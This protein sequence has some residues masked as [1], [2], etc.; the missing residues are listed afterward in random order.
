MAFQSYPDRVYPFFAAVP[1]YEAEGLDRV[2]E[3]LE[4]GYFG[5]GEIVGASTQS[6]MTSQLEW[7]SEH[8]NDGNLPEI[9]D[10]C[11]EYRVPILLHIDPPEGFPIQMLEEALTQHP[12]TV[13]VFAHANAYNTPQNIE[14]LVS[15][16]PNLYVDFFAGFTA[17]NPDSTYGLEDFVA[18]IEG[19]PDQFLVGTDSGYGVGYDSAALATYELLDLLTAETA[20]KVSHQ[21]IARILETQLPTESQIARIK[22]LSKL[23]GESG[24]QRLNKRMAHE[25]L[26]ELEAQVSNKNE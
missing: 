14:A 2:R 23:A 10:L 25:L 24:T 22:E 11:A 26:F 12:D 13:F 5:I 4:K 9:Y 17:Y 1:I 20:C 21:N 18:V 8:P 16:Y 6:P 7:K 19:Y 3:N 15:A